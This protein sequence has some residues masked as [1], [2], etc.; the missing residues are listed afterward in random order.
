MTLEEAMKTIENLKKSVEREKIKNRELELMYEQRESQKLKEQKKDLEDA[1][2]SNLKFI[3]KLLND[4]QELNEQCD[5]LMKELK[6][7]Q[8]NHERQIA[9]KKS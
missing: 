3:D 8:S 6:E 7:T 4:K 5:R 9:E 2:E 1:I